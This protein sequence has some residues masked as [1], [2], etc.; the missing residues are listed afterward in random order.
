VGERYYDNENRM[1]KVVQGGQTH[2]YF[3]DAS[4][5]RVRRIL[6]GSQTTG[7]QETWFVY[8]FDGEL[9]AEY[10]YNQASP[11]S[12]TA[13][14]KE[15]GYRNGKLLVVWD[16]TQSGDKRLKWLVTDHL[17]STRMEVDRSGSLAGIARIDLLPFGE[18]LSV[19]VG[20]RSAS[21]GYGGDSVRQKYTNKERDEETGLDYFG[22]RYFAIMQGRFTSPDPLIASAKPEQP[23]GWNR[24][25]YTINNPLKYVDPTGLI[26]GFLQSNAGD[27]YG[28]YENK[29]ALEKA[30]AAVVN[31]NA[32]GGFVYQSANGAWIRLDLGQNSWRGYETEGEAHVGRTLAEEGSSSLGDLGHTFNLFMNV[33]VGVGLAGGLGATT[34]GRIFGSEIT[35]L[36][37]SGGAAGTV[38]V[39]SSAGGDIAEMAFVRAISHGEKLS[40][41]AND[42]KQLTFSTGNEHALVKL[43]SGQRAI[44][45][46]GPGGINFAEGQISRLYAHTHPFQSLATGASAA[47]RMTI[48]ALGQRSSFLLEHG[49]IIKFTQSSEQV[50]QRKF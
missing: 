32:N 1:T 41:I 2:Y 17:G 27:R 36:G 28:W 46:G 10:T 39:A 45:A 26:W 35:T 5:K 37:L 18:Q 50:I 16:G 48:Q 40:G 23:Q 3:Y 33:Q 38:G 13:A 15:Y 21:I 19:G 14:V 43:A 6:N 7:G 24:Y 34:L 12:N 20:I 42:L 47:D 22:A 25:S 4:G 29:E 8:G 9:V 11:P 44:V 31:A 30:G 49:N